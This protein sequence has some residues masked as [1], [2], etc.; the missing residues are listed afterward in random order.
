M[1]EVSLYMYNQGTFSTLFHSH[2]Q[3]SSESSRF[4][5]PPHPPPSAQLPFRGE[6]Y[7]EPCIKVHKKRLFSNFNDEGEP[8]K[9]LV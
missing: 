6:K 4:S 7:L 2:C 1:G 9:P 3:P 5:S 8:K